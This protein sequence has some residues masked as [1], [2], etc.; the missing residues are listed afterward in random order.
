MVVLVG[1]DA[2]SLERLKSPTATRSV[3]RLRTRT[4]ACRDTVFHIPISV[5]SDGGRWK[6]WWYLAAY[7]VPYVTEVLYTTSGA[8]ERAF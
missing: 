3:I 8:K 2:R 1:N 4:R 5:R 7:N 6:S